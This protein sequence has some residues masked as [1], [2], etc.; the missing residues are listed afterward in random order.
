MSSNAFLVSFLIA[1]TVGV[2]DIPIYRYTEFIIQVPTNCAT[3]PPIK[4]SDSEPSTITASI[5]IPCVS[6]K[7]FILSNSLDH[8]LMLFDYFSIFKLYSIVASKVF[9]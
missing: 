6:P 5:L 7:D 4:Y 2:A 3:N 1:I 8:D 9:L